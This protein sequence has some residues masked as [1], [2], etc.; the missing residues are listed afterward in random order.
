MQVRDSRERRRRKKKR[1]DMPIAEEIAYDICEKYPAVKKMLE[2][3]D[4]KII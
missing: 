3:F 4:L 2:T 1:H